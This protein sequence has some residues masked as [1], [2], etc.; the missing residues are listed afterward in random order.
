MAREATGEDEQ[1]DEL[2]TALGMSCDRCSASWSEMPKLR[3]PDDPDE[4]L[5]SIAS[6]VQRLGRG[7]SRELAA[8]IRRARADAA[9]PPL[10]TR[11]DDD[12]TRRRL[13]DA[14]FDKLGSGDRRELSAMMRRGGG[15]GGAEQQT[16]SR[17]IWIPTRSAEALE[18]VARKLLD[19]GDDAEKVRDIVARIRRA[20]DDE[21]QR[22]AEAFRAAAHRE[23]N[24]QVRGYGS[25]LQPQ[26]SSRRSATSDAGA[27]RKRKAK[28]P[29]QKQRQQ[30]QQE[31]EITVD[32]VLAED[33]P[34]RGGAGA[35]SE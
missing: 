13:L 7:D 18:D 34:L 20:R 26:A 33:M 32:S 24:P 11:S 9:A 12:P 4:A 29:G 31:G 6:E 28:K 5:E 8:A 15:G 2:C 16:R 30:E 22:A 14:D 27:E 25:L 3:V 1:D 19:G 17:W 10:M 21:H 35:A 23:F